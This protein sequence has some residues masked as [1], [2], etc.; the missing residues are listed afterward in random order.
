[1]EEKEIKIGARVRIKSNGRIGYVSAI[2][3][4][5][6]HVCYFINLGLPIKFPAKREWVELVETDKNE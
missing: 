1:M 2:K 3:D 6:T 5:G 4:Y